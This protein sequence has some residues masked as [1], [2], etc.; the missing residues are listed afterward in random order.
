[1]CRRRKAAAAFLDEELRGAERARWSGDDGGEPAAI[2]KLVEDRG[3]HL[4]H[5]AL[6]QDDVIRAG[7]SRLHRA[8]L[9]LDVGKRQLPR[10][11]AGGG[12]ERGIGFDGDNR[13]HE[14]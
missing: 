3:R 2:H 12:S 1:V 14:P 4:L 10:R 7:G 6:D 13:L 11:L 8:N 5:G 9:L